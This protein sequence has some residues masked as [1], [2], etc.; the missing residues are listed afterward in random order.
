MNEKTYRTMSRIGGANIAMGVIMMVTGVVLGVLMTVSG[1]R[2][3]KQ[4]YGI[5]I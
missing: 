4:K 1:A 5:T 3:L 2:L